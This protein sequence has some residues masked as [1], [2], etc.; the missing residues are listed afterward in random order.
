MWF[1]EVK[2]DTGAL[3]LFF[4][5]SPLLVNIGRPISGS[6]RRFFFV[7]FLIGELTLSFFFRIHFD[8]CLYYSF[9]YS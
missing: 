6:A 2:L 8:V 3:D 4:T 5:A 7:F 9:L 1:F